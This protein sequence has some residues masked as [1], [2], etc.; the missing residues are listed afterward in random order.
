M[1]SLHTGLDYPRRSSDSSISAP[2]DDLD[3]RFERDVLPLRNRLYG[4]AFRLTG[5]KHDAEDL[6]QETIL[7]AYAGFRTFREGTQLMAWLYRIMRN[8][9]INQYRRKKRRGQEDFVGSITDDQLATYA[10]HNV[11]PPR[12]AEVAALEAMPDS[13]IRSALMALREETRMAV[14][15]ADVAGYKYGEIADMMNTPVG[16]VMSRL[17]RGRRRLRSTLSTVASQR[18]FAAGAAHDCRVSPAL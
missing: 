12:S 7:H 9:W 6:V 14:Y 3:A 13:E 1:M 5:N 2:D 18:G 17:N 11:D 16:T 8:N 15:Y 10:A 4:A